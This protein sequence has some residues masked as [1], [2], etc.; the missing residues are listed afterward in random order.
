MGGI[1]PGKSGLFG[2][3]WDLSRAHRGLFGANRDQ[4]LCT[5][6][7]LG[8]ERAEIPPKGPF[9]AQVAP[10]GQSPR[11]DFPD[12][13]RSVFR[14]A[15]SFGLGIS[16]PYSAPPIAIA[17]RQRSAITTDHRHFHLAEG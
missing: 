6:Q 17:D 15:G 13:I 14:V 8:G 16:D 10:F 12:A 7:P 9:L 5:S 3:D 1:R 4:F 2:A 11:L